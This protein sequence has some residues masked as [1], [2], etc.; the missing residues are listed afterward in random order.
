MAYTKR[1]SKDPMPTADN[2]A[3]AG[4]DGG[5]NTPYPAGAEKHG[6]G[7]ARTISASQNRSTGPTAMAVPQPTRQNGDGNVPVTGESHDQAKAR[8]IPESSRW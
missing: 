2:S 3:R 1:D 4:K 5:G 7:K 6:Q 8:T